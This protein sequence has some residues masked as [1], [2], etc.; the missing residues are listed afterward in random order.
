MAL[1]LGV[2]QGAGHRL[3]GPA[4][5]P[6]RQCRC[7]CST[8]PNGPTAGRTPS[9]TGQS[10]TRVKKRPTRK[11]TLIC[12]PTRYIHYLGPPSCGATHDYQLLKNELDVNLGL[13]DLFALL[14]DLGYLGLVRDYDVAPESLPHRKSRRSKKSRPLP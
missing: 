6:L 8:P 10:T 1:A 3:A 12:D 5:G 7:S 2:L 9:W 13:L 4:A 11:N 14:A